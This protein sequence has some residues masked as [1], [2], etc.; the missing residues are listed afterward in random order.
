MCVYGAVDPT[1]SDGLA[2][3]GAS[4][5][6]GDPYVGGSLWFL[7]CLAVVKFLFWIWHKKGASVRGILDY[8]LLRMFWGVHLEIMFI[9][10][11]FWAGR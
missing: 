2:A 6:H 11:F 3:C 7:T 5:F 8:S 4:F 9:R 1:L 10:R